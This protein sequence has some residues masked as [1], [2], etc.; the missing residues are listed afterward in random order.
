LIV[1]VVVYTV[2]K[3]KLVARRQINSF[4]TVWT[5]VGGMTIALGGGGKILVTG[6]IL[7]KRSLTGA[8]V[9]RGMAV[10]TFPPA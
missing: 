9:A 6:R 4:R 8:I 5:I 1:L 10:L 7:A 2:S 3:I